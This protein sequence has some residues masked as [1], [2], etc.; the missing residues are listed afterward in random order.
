MSQI[1][2]WNPLI[3]QQFQCCKQTCAIEVNTDGLLSSLSTSKMREEVEYR[4]S[5]LLFNMNIL[6]PPKGFYL[7]HVSQRWPLTCFLQ[8]EPMNRRAAVSVKEKYLFTLW[9]YAERLLTPWHHFHY[10]ISHHAPSHPSE[11][12]LG[13]GSGFNT[14]ASWRPRVWDAAAP[15]QH[16]N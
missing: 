3:S 2:A 1:F 11:R 9:N 13:E 16:K 10:L 5:S 12:G 14:L 6:F 7:F 4:S 8:T 15:D